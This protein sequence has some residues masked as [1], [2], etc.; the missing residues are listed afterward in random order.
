MSIDESEYGE[1]DDTGS[2]IEQKRQPRGCGWLLGRKNK[3]N[4]YKVNKIGIHSGYIRGRSRR[5]VKYPGWLMV[6][7]YAL[8]FCSWR[9]F[10]QRSDL[11]RFAVLPPK[12]P[13]R[14]E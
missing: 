14:P 5:C 2:K 9:L 3:E 1:Q 6:V 12:P 10:H 4:D 13:I 8:E 7:A 11:F